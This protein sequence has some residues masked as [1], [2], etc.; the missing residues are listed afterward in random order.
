MATT[1]YIGARYVPVVYGE[2]ASGVQYEPLTIVT[3]L[4]Q[5]YT[6]K[7]PV[8]ATVGNPADNGTYWALTGAY[9]AQMA[10]LSQEVQDLETKFDDANKDH[11]IVIGDSLTAGIGGQTADGFAGLAA[12]ALGFTTDICKIS[13]VGGSAFTT[14]T[15]TFLQ[16]LNEVLA[17]ASDEFKASKVRVIVVSGMHNDESHASDY[18]DAVDAFVARCRDQ[19]TNCTIEMLPI[20]WS[21]NAERR[22]SIVNFYN[23]YVSQL[24]THGITVWT[25]L[26]AWLHNYS[27]WYRDDIHPSATGITALSKVMT[28]VYR[29]ESNPGVM[30]ALKRPK[31][32]TN[33]NASFSA[34]TN[35]PI[36][37]EYYDGRMVW[38]IGGETTMVTIGASD[39][40]LSTSALSPTELCDNP[41]YYIGACA[42]TNNRFYGEFPC[43]VRQG[44]NIMNGYLMVNSDN[45]LCIYTPI[46]FTANANGVIEVKI[47]GSA[48]PKEYC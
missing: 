25:D 14:G 19:L 39:V 46:E 28:G 42:T 35:F 31:T 9:N 6:S 15:K 32:P 18:I 23:T 10:Q 13:A 30:A 22:I 24:P 11:Y 26:F 45:K 4:N 37:R 3:Y 29:N 12:S 7:K 40:T 8:P 1:Q 44:N 34:M 20:A 47:I 38:L 16:Q 48:H 43:T 27:D 2:W 5:S 41:F 21:K 17:A 36:M 33:V